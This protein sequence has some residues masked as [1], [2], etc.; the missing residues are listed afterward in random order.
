MLQM[1]LVARLLRGFSGYKTKAAVAPV[2]YVNS[3]GKRAQSVDMDSDEE[4]GLQ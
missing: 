3:N 1:A 4:D 2:P